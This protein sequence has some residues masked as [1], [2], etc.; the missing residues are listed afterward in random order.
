MTAVASAGAGGALAGAASSTSG[1]PGQVITVEVATARS[2]VA[3]VRAWELQTDGQYV[4]V[5]GP[6]RA[7]VGR[8]GVG[9]VR[10]GSGRTPAGVFTLTRAFGSEPNNGTRL[11]YVR[12]GPDDWWDENPVSAGYNELV[13]SRVSPGGDSENLYYSGRA[14]AHAV[15]IN[16]NTHPIIKGMG[17]GM[18][19]HVGNGTATSGCVSISARSLNALMRWL[20]P[21]QHPVISIGVGA[22]AQAIVAGVG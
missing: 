22:A 12:T 9:R 6:M 15:V 1:P 2:V 14:Y 4:Q 8:N 19:L 20:D 11:P 16:Y 21:A 3:I 5:M 13:I 17:S 10:E 7:D 18:F